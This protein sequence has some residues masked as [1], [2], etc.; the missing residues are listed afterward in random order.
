M[1]EE[2]FQEK[3][4][5]PSPKR[6]QDAREKGQVARSA[7]IGTALLMLGAALA[8]STGGRGTARGIGDVFARSATYIENPPV[9]IDATARW[10]GDLGFGVLGAIAPIVL[11]VSAVAL[12]GGAVQARGTFSLHPLKPDFSRLS[13]SK[14]LKRIFGLRSIVEL[15][16]SLVKLLIVGGAVWFSLSR[17][18]PDMAALPQQPAVAFLAVVFRYVV[19][20]LM[21]SGLAFLA[22][23]G[24]DYAYQLWDFEK[25]LRMTKQEVKQEMKETEGDPMVKSRLRAFGRSLVRKRMMQAV[26]TAD[27]VVTNPTHIAVALKYDPTIAPA[28][29]V[30][31]MGQRKIAERIKKIALE[32]GVPVVEN[33]PLARALLAT[34]R[35][36]MPIPPE[37]YV[38]VAE[39]LAFVIR[40]RGRRWAGATVR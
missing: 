31:A 3:T 28:P 9:G 20:L 29:I 40:R 6:R 36:D 16:K 34:A 32:A 4:E 11:G 35:L 23:A 24:A 18:W 17:A 22:L 15:L 12:A 10:L 38:A 1:A 37:L 14:N 39:V 33:R 25:N 7:E 27:V 13:P 26:P 19:R 30:V 5:A 2:S 8:L 21:V